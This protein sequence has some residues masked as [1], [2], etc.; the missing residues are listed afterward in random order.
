MPP[1]ALVITARA[2]QRSTDLRLCGFPCR[3]VSGRT[4]STGTYISDARCAA[5][6]QRNACVGTGA[7][8]STNTSAYTSTSRTSTSTSTGTSTSIAA[9]T[10]TLILGVCCNGWHTSNYRRCFGLPA[11][12]TGSLICSRSQQLARFLGCVHRVLGDQGEY[13]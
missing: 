4:L 8:T 1:I 7:S 12:S 6:L 11:S 3:P 10:G 9:T 13:V 2:V 5:R